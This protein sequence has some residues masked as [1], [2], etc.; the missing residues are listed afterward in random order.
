MHQ[1][2]R[3]LLM[4]STKVLYL[5]VKAADV[6]QAEV[7]WQQK[8]VTVHGKTVMQP[9]MVAYMADEPSLAYTYSR[10]TMVPDAWT[11]AVRVIKVSW[12]SLSSVGASLSTVT[13]AHSTARQDGDVSGSPVCKLAG[14]TRVGDWRRLQFLPPESVPQWQRPHELSL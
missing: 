5:A 4:R 10:Q 3:T 13:C 8:E 6:M 1:A 7:A 14:Q 11:P 2:V 9:R 12:C